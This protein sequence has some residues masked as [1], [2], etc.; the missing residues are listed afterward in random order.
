MTIRYFL[1]ILFLLQAITNGMAQNHSAVLT[2]T[3]Y[4]EDGT[5]L[6]G[7]IIKLEGT[8]MGT[9]TD[10]NG[11]FLLK[12]IP[13]GK[14]TVSCSAMGYTAQ[15]KEVT[16]HAHTKTSLTFYLKENGQQ[17]NE[18]IVFGKSEATL[19]RES[20]KAVTV[21]DTKEAKLQTADLGEVLSTVSGVNVRRSGGLGSSN[22]FSLNGLTDDQIRFMLDGIPLDIMGYSS[23]IANVPVNLVERVE[24]YKGVVP[25][26]LGADALGGAVNLVSNTSIDDSKGAVSYQIG[27]FG[28]HR[29]SLEGQSNTNTKGMYVRGSGYYDYAKNNYLVDVEVVGGGGKLYDATLPRFHDSYKSYGLRG[30]VGWV[31]QAWADEFSLELFANRTYRDI[32]NNNVMSIVYGEVT[33]QNANE[34]ALLRYRQELEGININFAAGYTFDQVTFVDTSRYIYTWYGDVVRNANG[35]PRERSPGELGQATDRQIWDHNTYARL[36]LEYQLGPQHLLRLSSAPTYVSRSGNERWDEEN[37]LIDPLN[38]INTLFTWVNGLEY[39]LQSTDERLENSLFAKH[40]FQMVRAEEPTNTLGVTRNMDREAHNSG[41]GNSM[42][43]H[44]HPQWMLKASYEWATRLPRPQEIFGNG[45]LI[46]P[47]LS[48]KPERSH[49]VNLAIHFS[50]PQGSPGSW[51]FSL[52]GFLRGTDQLILLLGNNEVFS[53]Q[54]VFA[55]R[56]MGVEANAFWQSANER[57]QVTANTT[58][59]DFRN[60]SS[61]GDFGP[62]AGD[63]IPNRPYFFINNSFGYNIPKL[64]SNE[65]NLHL[66]LKNRYVHEFY[67]GWE[68]VGLKRFKAIIPAQFIQH[69][70]ATYQMPFKGIQTSLTAEAH[71]LTNAEVYDFFGVQKPGRAYYLKLTT[72]F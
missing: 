21:V 38:E 55:A 35:E 48:L 58:V 17:L 44:L 65:G 51:E 59:Q 9:V 36:G 61:K 12:G 1:T 7:I 50:N 6:P 54:N 71:N 49:N 26:D 32:Q 30:T 39:R 20:A 25:V 23:G 45:R 69:A 42:R 56:S 67:K 43:Y 72:T 27:S 66:F 2:G 11:L 10:E 4:Q 31:D 13:P 60:R 63:R 3:V 46:L 5:P 16:I 8:Q 15:N 22:R 24:I 70:G 68:S 53:Y 37:E 40:Y 57:L 28:T 29:L 41:F 62:Y 34:G 64:L 52:N 19:L 14:Q 18:V 33:S 47:N